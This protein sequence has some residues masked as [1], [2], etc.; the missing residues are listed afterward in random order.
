MTPQEQ[1]E[2]KQKWMPGHMVRLHS[3]LR[4]Q[5]IDW[6]KQWMNPIHWKHTK[7]TGVY[8]DTF[9]FEKLAQAKGLAEKF[10]QYAKLIVD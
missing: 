4:S 3:D 9:H 6:C 5:G 10:P 8:E 2:Y 1:F 7:W